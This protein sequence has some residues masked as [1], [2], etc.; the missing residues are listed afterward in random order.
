MPWLVE[1]LLCINGIKL[2]SESM[3]AMQGNISGRNFYGEVHL[4]FSDSPDNN[5]TYYVG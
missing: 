3:A 4:F 5:I 1:V 2:T